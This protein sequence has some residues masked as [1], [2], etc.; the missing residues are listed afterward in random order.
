MIFGSKVRNVTFVS[1]GHL[2]NMQIK[3]LPPQESWAT[4]LLAL[5]WYFNL[6]S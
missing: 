2:G 6:V 3:Y 4:I 5:M 1:G